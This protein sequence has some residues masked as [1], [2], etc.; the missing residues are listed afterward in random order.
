MKKS[1][2]TS[3]LVSMCINREFIVNTVFW[4][5]I[6]IHILVGP[7]SII[8]NDQRISQQIATIILDKVY[9][10]VMCDPTLIHSVKQTV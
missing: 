10:N 6:L 1:F 8:V 5:V 2:I 3:G 9:F 7:M 4:Q